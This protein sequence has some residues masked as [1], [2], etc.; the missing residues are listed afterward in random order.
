VVDLCREK[1]KDYQFG[2][3]LICQNTG[4]NSFIIDCDAVENPDKVLSQWVVESYR[5]QQNNSKKDESLV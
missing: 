5:K 1:F 2:L 3:R 4:Q